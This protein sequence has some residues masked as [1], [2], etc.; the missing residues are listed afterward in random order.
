MRQAHGFEHRRLCAPDSDGA[1]IVRTYSP[2]ARDIGI[3]RK[4]VAIPR[5]RVSS[6]WIP[7]DTVYASGIP[8]GH[9]RSTPFPYRHRK[10]NPFVR[11]GFEIAGGHGGTRT[12]WNSGSLATRKEHSSVVTRY[13]GPRSFWRMWGEG[14]VSFCG[15]FVLY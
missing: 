11:G 12:R 5:N 2:L 7:T 3:L 14:C 15:T 8:I 6:R 4:K 10:R 9:H 13:R 1:R